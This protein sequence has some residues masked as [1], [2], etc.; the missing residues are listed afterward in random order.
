MIVEQLLCLGA[1]FVNGWMVW[2]KEW[3]L[4][5]SETP[6]QQPFS[7]ALLSSPSQQP[8]S[9]M[10]LSADLSQQPFS[11]APFSAALFSGHPPLLSCCG[12]GLVVSYQHHVAV[13]KGW[14]SAINII[15]WSRVGSQL[16][17]SS[18]CGQRLVVNY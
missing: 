10:M 6:F 16:L 5:V 11:A 8:S 9:A 15:L 1:L 17:T 12:Q 2:T 14:C 4:G 3:M 7:A 13:V 18:R